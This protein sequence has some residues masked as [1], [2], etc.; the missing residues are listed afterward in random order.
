[1]TLQATV[2]MGWVNTVIATAQNQGVTGEVLH[3]DCGFRN[4]LTGIPEGG[5]GT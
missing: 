4:V 2:S 1:M 5:N 3:V